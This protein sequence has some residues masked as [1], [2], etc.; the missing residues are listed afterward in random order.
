MADDPLFKRLQDIHVFRT[1]HAKL[2]SVITSTFGK[3][4]EAGSAAGGGDFRSQ[5]LTDI[6]EAFDSV[7]KSNPDVLDTSQQG[8]D[9]WKASLKAYEL[10]TAKIESQLTQLLK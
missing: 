6:K 2:E 9:N 3:T 4:A 5:A 10:S 8:N 7:V 1:D